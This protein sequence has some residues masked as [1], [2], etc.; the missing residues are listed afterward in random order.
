ML[1]MGK[2]L[3]KNKRGFA[4]RGFFY[5]LILCAF[6]GM[7][8]GV[9]AV[10]FIAGGYGADPMSTLLQGMSQT[11]Q[12]SIDTCNNLLSFTFVLTAFLIDR[13]QIHAGT[14]VFPLVTTIT[15]WILTPLVQADTQ[16]HRVLFCAAGI[17]IIAISI[18]L[19]I[20][21]DCGKNPYDCVTF[22][23]MKKTKL[24][25]HVIRWILD[26]SMLLTGIMMQGTFGIVTIINLLVLGKLITV[27]GY[28]MD[29][30]YRLRGPI[31]KEEE[32]S[33]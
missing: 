27:I 4:H 16:L 26:G 20:R 12:L 32:I 13:K 1:A 22:G 10:L 3:I 17:L 2:C 6:A 31:K 11:L 33:L 28:L 25:Y 15:M 5:R 21:A 14:V 24:P 19:S 18:A 29:S 9:A 23:L 30:L 8:M 7:L